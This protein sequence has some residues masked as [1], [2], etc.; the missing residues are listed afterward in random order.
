L[1]GER[2]EVA[3]SAVSE[4]LGAAPVSASW[5]LGV[6]ALAAILLVQTSWLGTLAWL[7]W[8]LSR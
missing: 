3:A 4:A 8:L 2:G 5:V 7:A 6:T 1:G